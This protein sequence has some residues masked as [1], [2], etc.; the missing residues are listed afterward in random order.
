MKFLPLA[1]GWSPG[2]IEGTGRAG[3]VRPCFGVTPEKDQ[4]KP[5]S[6]QLVFGRRWRLRLRLRLGRRCMRIRIDLIREGFAARFERFDDPFEDGLRLRGHA[7]R[8]V[9]AL[10]C[11][12]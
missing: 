2:E 10:A 8:I 5:E 12:F 7:L 11:E 9:A 1:M 6:N 4:E 3:K